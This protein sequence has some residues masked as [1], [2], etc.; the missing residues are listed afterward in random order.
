MTREL[1]AVLAGREIGRIQ[2]DKR[3][4][5][6]FTYAEDWREAP[7]AHCLSLS[8]PIAAAEHPHT[9]TENFLWGLLPDNEAILDRWAR[10]FHVSARSPFALIA[11]VGED[12]AGAV[13]FVRPER[14][15]TCLAP[16][17]EPVEWLDEQGVAM[18][19]RLLQADHSAWRAP[20]D[21][22]QFSLAGAQPK[23]A[24]LLEAGRW[25]IPSGPTPTTHILKPRTAAFD[26][27][28]ENEHFCLA[29]A[30]RLGLPTARSAIVRFEDQSAIV[31]ERY[32]RRRSETGV[33]RVH[34]EDVCQALGVPPTRKYQNEGGPGVTEIV[35][36]LR[37]HSS[38]REQDL[39][40]FLDSVG[41]SWLSAGTDAHAKNFSLL[42]GSAGRVRLAP[43]YDLASAL[44]YED[45]PLQ[46]LKLAMKIG[47]DYRL[48]DVGAR[49]W[50]R[51][52]EQV[53]IDPDDLLGRIGTLAARLPEEA[54]SL[55][56]RLHSEGLGHEVIDRL[57]DRLSAR[58]D[59]CAK[60][61][62][63]TA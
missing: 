57:A 37:T 48:R 29:L 40:T 45:L 12:C 14:L 9:I 51:F 1:V 18:R 35:E 19:L 34:Q 49:E 2:R 7:E 23:T 22:G 30:R 61:L 28:A 10:R 44:A 46:K 17:P 52:A 60:A 56:D 41:F 33:L 47:P 6:S 36:L 63:R 8:M 43:L 3:G 31:I 58:A 16:E 39:M 21:T 5:L 20:R 53:R 26:G 32:D 62:E 38:D 59:D 4:R 55:R 50:R 24:L 27:H 13:Q 11:H 15:E 54:H 25:G 42:I